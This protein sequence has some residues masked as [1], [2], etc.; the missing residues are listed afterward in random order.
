M[1]PPTVG[2][3]I[4]KQVNKSNPQAGEII[5]YTL[6][7]INIGQAPAT[8][9]HVSDALPGGITFVGPVTLTPSGALITPTLPT[10]ASG[11]T[12][13][14]GGR[15]TL[16]FPV[17]VDPG[18]TAG[19]ILTNTASVTSTEVATP[20]TSAVPV[21]VVPSPTPALVL[22]KQVSNPT[23]Q[24]GSLV[25]YTLLVTNTSQVDASG[26]RISDTLPAGLTFI[27]PI[28]LN[29]P[30]SGASGNAGTLPTL[31]SN[32]V[33]NAGQRLT[34]TFP[35]RVNQNV[36]SG[37]VI[38]NRASVTS[39]QVATPATGQVALRVIGSTTGR[40]FLPLILKTLPILPDLVGS[41]T[42][43]PNQSNF[44]A[45]TPVTVRVVVTNVGAATADSFWVDF[46]I[47][48]AGAPGVNVPW[49]QT[50]SL[51]PCYGIAWFVPPGLDP[52]ESVI[53][54]ST[55]AS[56]AAPQTIWPGSFAAGT[57][58]LYLYVDSWNP[59]VD[60]GGVFESNE[61]NNGAEQHGLTVTGLGACGAQLPDPAQ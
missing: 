14:S 53:L 43:S 25:T 32:V 39:T 4:L 3:D 60:A 19:T 13:A 50:C 51:S 21:I 16:T 15:L 20:T 61:L 29:P 40:L 56:Y 2:L 7:V 31:A 30:A 26:M 54:T 27:G 46:Y 37:T 35:V 24:A 55:P 5:T 23:P 33:L 9:I 1:P 44:A 52:G 28:S 10:L 48:P 38:T 45:G 57:S 22:T 36:V 6:V 42:L 47:N 58:D 12:L 11:L 41:F 18:I 59:T 8:N 49:N 34:L 17:R